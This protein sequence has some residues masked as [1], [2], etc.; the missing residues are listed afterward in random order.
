MS[1]AIGLP[2]FATVLGVLVIRLGAAERSPL[3]ASP[4]RLAAAPQSAPAAPLGVTSPATV[5]RTPGATAVHRRAPRDVG[6]AEEKAAGRP[7]GRTVGPG[8]APT[9]DPTRPEI[10]AADAIMGLRAEGE[11]EGI[12]AFGL[13]GTDPPKPGVIVPEGFELPEGFVRH[14]QNTDDGQQ[15]PAILMVHPDYELV[16]A[17]GNR[18][19]TPD[20]IVPPEL[21]P[22]GIP[23]EILQVPERRTRTNLPD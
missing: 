19:T 4:E 18:V 11:T 17:A 21:A 2:I 20:G 13:P 3:S 6:P 8:P 23:I 7:A 1:L 15:L 22:P 12:A 14:Y 5:A 10:D 9:V 16:D